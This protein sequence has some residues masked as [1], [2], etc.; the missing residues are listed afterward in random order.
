MMN[1][2]KH[3]A[4]HAGL[5]NMCLARAVE[6]DQMFNF[7]HSLHYVT[8]SSLTEVTAFSGQH[9]QGMGSMNVVC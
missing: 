3:C 9:L 4:D 1:T 6:D 2:S 5:P 7:E 8:I